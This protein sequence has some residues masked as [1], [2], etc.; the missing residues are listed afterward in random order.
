[1]SGAV[2]VIVAGIAM[3]FIGW[4]TQSGQVSNALF[5]VGVALAL[6]GCIALIFGYRT[7][8]P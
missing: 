8:R 7:P 1:M 5:I 6:M 4:F 3:M 2:I